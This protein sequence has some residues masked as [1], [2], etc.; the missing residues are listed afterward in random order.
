MG[1]TKIESHNYRTHPVCDDNCIIH[2]DRFLYTTHTV[3]KIKSNVI[4]SVGRYELHVFIQ[5]SQGDSCIEGRS[6]W[7]ELGH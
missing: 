4:N 2:R 3:I 5:C 1:V 7:A 6:E